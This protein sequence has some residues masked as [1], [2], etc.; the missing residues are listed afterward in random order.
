MFK[1]YKY[2]EIRRLGIRSRSWIVRKARD[3][4]KQISKMTKSSS[5]GS[6]YESNNYMFNEE[7]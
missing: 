5:E 3:Q 6:K 4:A 7:K 1:N 2:E